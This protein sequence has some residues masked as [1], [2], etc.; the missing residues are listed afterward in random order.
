M[1]NQQ[2]IKWLLEGV[3]AWNTRRQR[4]SFKPD[5]YGADLQ[6]ILKKANML[7]MANNS[8]PNETEIKRVNLWGANFRDADLG[9]ANLWGADLRDVDFCGANLKGAVLG[10]ALILKVRI[11]KTQTLKMPT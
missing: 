7:N 3:N 10:E 4:D 11:F 8:D 5:F 1:A 9:R 2:H 6:M